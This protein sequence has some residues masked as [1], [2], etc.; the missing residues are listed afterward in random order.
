[1]SRCLFEY[2]AAIAQ[3]G[4]RQTEYLEV[5]GSIPSL[6]MLDV[7]RW[8]QNF[9]VAKNVTQKRKKVAKV[10]VGGLLLSRIDWAFDKESIPQV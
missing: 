8:N 4:E 1:M 3:L 9:S 7:L 5:S 2:Q 6:G 10:F